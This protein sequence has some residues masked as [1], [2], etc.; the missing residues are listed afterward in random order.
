MR[1][2]VPFIIALII[3]PAFIFNMHHWPAGK[4]ADKFKKH[5]ETV[6][7]CAN[8][9]HS[10]CNNEQLIAEGQ[11]LFHELNEEI[12]Y[13]GTL[14]EV[15]KTHFKV[16]DNA[17]RLIKRVMIEKDTKYYLSIYTINKYIEIEK[18]FIP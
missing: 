9:Q 2:I 6:I 12:K 16:Y 13:H 10:N 18:A 17:K 5:Y 7:I 4:W 8:N 3:A 1:S 14:D 11:E 15:L